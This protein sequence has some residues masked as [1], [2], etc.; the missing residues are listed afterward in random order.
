MKKTSNNNKTAQLN[1]GAVMGS[2]FY[3]NVDRNIK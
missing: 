1:I 2:K 3:E